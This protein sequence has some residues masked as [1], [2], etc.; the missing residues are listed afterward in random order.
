[1]TITSNAS[2]VFD[3]HCHRSI[4]ETR[5]YRIHPG[6]YLSF[7]LPYLETSGLVGLIQLCLD[8]HMPGQ[9]RFKVRLTDKFKHLLHF[10]VPGRS[11]PSS[12]RLITPTIDPQASTLVG[13]DPISIPGI[14]D[15]TPSLSNI[16]PSIVIDPAGDE[17]PE[18][19]GDLASARFQGVKTTLRLVERA[20]DVF[21]PLKSTIGGLLGV[22]DIV[23]VR[24]FQ[25]SIV[26]VMMLTVPTTSQTTAQNQE[27]CQDLER[28][29]RAVVSVINNHAN[30]S[31]TPTFTK[32]LEGLSA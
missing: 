3:H 23:E 25:L 11:R 8:P 10:L 28:K 2:S 22:I 32:R 24:D 1:M 15:S 27:D 17:A 29:L 20:T 7:S 30:Y 19:M 12:N 6:A 4:T 5:A 16:Y 18:R 9:K 26:I 13:P 21:T 31:T 14:P